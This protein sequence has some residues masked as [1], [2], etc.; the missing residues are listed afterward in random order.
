MRSR[1]SCRCDCS[2]STPWM[3]SVKHSPDSSQNTNACGSQRGKLRRSVGDS[4]ESQRG[5]EG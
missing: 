2:D 5:M 3:A 1:F 4:D